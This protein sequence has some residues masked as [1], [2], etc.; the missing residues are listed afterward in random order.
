VY[1]QS[2]EISAIT[3]EKKQKGELRGIKQQKRDTIE[4]IP[5]LVFHAKG[6]KRGGLESR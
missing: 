1:Q 6:T 5:E 2:G 3:F 4:P